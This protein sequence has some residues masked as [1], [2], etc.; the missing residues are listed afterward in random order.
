MTS[1]TLDL[2]NLPSL[3][4]LG[5]DRF[6]VLLHGGPGTGKTTLAGSIAEVGKTLFIDL[7][8]EKGTDSL[9]G[10]P[11]SEN[12]VPFRPTRTEQIDEVLWTLIDG[13]HPFDAV[14]IDGVSAWHTMYVRYYNGLE[15][16]RPRKKERGAK[17]PKKR[18]G[19]Q[20]YG[21]ANDAL[22]DDMTFWF[23]LADASAIK[24]I[25]VVMTSQTRERESREG[26]EDWRLGP[27]VSPGALRK[28]EAAPNYIG[29]CAIEN[30]AGDEL[31][32]EEKE[33]SREDFRYTVR[34]GPHSSIM[35]KTHEPLGAGKRW[36]DVVGRDGKRLTLPKMMKFLGYL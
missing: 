25:H 29:Y 2:T 31:S 6:K 16:D 28:V 14:V 1:D 34:F 22:S 19:R 26:A 15:E 9:Q 8:G 33:Q 11:G 17:A 35:T 10:M 4:D 18:D 36:P 24:P 27:D 21:E 32:F 30:V 5:H 3:D 13:N 7:P 23:A 12:I 20:V